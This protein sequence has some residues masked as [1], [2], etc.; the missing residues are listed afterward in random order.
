MRNA[1]HYR[2]SLIYSV[3]MLSVLAVAG[4]VTSGAKGAAGPP[5]LGDRME[6][7]R[8]CYRFTAGVSFE[9]HPYV[10]D[11]DNDGL[12]DL[13]VGV[14]E[15]NLH[16][17]ANIGSAS[18]PAL[19]PP[20][21]VQNAYGDI[22]VGMTA[23]PVHHDWNADGR[24]DLLVGD[25][26]GRVAFFANI[27]TDS[28][29]IF[30][31][32]TTLTAGGVTLDV[33][34]SSTP[35]VA[36]WNNDGKDD[37]LV[38]E[39]DGNINLFINT[40]T[41]AAPVLAAGVLL[42][43]GG[44][45]IDM[46]VESRPFV[47]DWNGDGRKDL[48]SN[49]KPQWRLSVFINTGTDAAPSF[50][51]ETVLYDE[52][53]AVVYTADH[54]YCF[55]DVN[56]DGADDLI[57]TDA[58]EAAMYYA[59]Q[60]DNDDRM[61]ETATCFPGG[62]MEFF[63]EA[64]S[65][66]V[67]DWDED[68]RKDIFMTLGHDGHHY[69]FFNTGTNA[70]PELGAQWRVTSTV[71]GKLGFSNCQYNSPVI[72][73]WDQDG[74]KDLLIVR[75]REYDTGDVLLYLNQGENYHP[76]FGAGEKLLTSDYT[77]LGPEQS[78]GL[79]VVDWNNDGKKDLCI[80][81]NMYGG[82][83][84]DGGTYQYL[85]INQGT[86][87]APVFS[88]GTP[89]MHGEPGYEAPMFATWGMSPRIWDYEEDGDF[90]ILLNSGAESQKLTNYLNDGLAGAPHFLCQGFLQADGADLHNTCF[91]IPAVVDWNEDGKKDI[92]LGAYPDLYWYENTQAAS[93][94]PAEVTALTVAGVTDSSISLA[95]T[96]PVEDD[97][98]GVLIVRSSAAIQWLPSDQQRYYPAPGVEVAPGVTVVY[99]AGGDHSFTPWTDTGLA[100]GT[101]YY[102]RA[103]S[104][105]AILPL[106]SVSGVAVSG[107]TSGDT[108]TPTPSP[109]ATATPSPTG[110]PTEPPVGPPE[111]GAPVEI[112]REAH[113]PVQDDYYY[114]PFLTD[115]DNDGRLDLLTGCYSGTVYLSMN[116]GTSTS[117]QMADA[118]PL[119][120][121]YST[122]NVGGHSCP[123]H[124]DW[125]ADGKRDLLVGNYSGHI[126]FYEN[127]GS[128]TAPLF[129][130][131]LDLAADYATID[132]GYQANPCVVDWNNDTLPDLVAGASDG[133]IHLFLNNGSQGNPQLGPEILVE[134]G[135]T[136]INT[137]WGSSPRVADWNG[138]GR[139]D[140]LTG[141]TNWPP[142]VALFLNTGT[143]Q[144]PVFDGATQLFTD[145]SAVAYPYTAGWTL[146][147]ING[148]TLED[149]VA[150]SPIGSFLF[151]P[152]T[153]DNAD[154][155]FEYALYIPG[156]EPTRLFGRGKTAR[157]I[158]WDEDGRKDLFINAEWRARHY[159]VLNTGTATEPAFTRQELLRTVDG[160]RI[161]FGD[162][163]Y[164]FPEVVDWDND[165]RKDLLVSSLDYSDTGDVYLYLNQGENYDPAFAA[166][167]KL[168]SGYADIGP[169]ASRSLE[170]ADWN[171]DGKKDLLIG[172]YI[173]GANGMY[174][175]VMLNSGTDAAPV[176]DD[177]SILTFENGYTAPLPGNY[178]C[179]VRVW[180][181]EEDGDPDIL[182][183]TMNDYER[184]T[185]YINDGV[186]GS[187]HLVNGGFIQAD[188]YDLY[189][190]DIALPE[191]TDWD[192]DGRKDLLVSQ[193]Y[194]MY[195]YPNTQS[196]QSAPPEAVDF[197]AVA[198]DD[199]AVELTW[200]NPA[201]MDFAG[202]IIVRSESSI[203]WLPS[204]RQHYHV[205]PG[206]EVASGVTVVYTGAGDHSASPWMDSGLSTGIEY[207]YRLFTFDAVLPSY[208]VQGAE[209]SVTASAPS[210]TPEPSP[211]VEPSPT[212]PPSPTPTPSPTTPPTAV[213]TDT[214]AVTPTPTIT[215]PPPPVPA[216]GPMG[217]LLAIVLLS[218][219][220]VCG[221]KRVQYACQGTEKP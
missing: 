59:N 167:V 10:T 55:G 13:L 5:E 42:A 8:E 61:Y 9:A 115:W 134:A 208:S 126:Q 16:L 108:P 99:A 154:R 125:N 48:F 121:D 168:S 62:S 26:S 174:Q 140:L 15:G 76:E 128:D 199:E 98:G 205:T 149:F 219:L 204:D 195:W 183:S 144:A 206:S 124:F 28:V 141:S 67:V 122:L 175:Y 19:A 14:N 146:G 177:L 173:Y 112:L 78:T 82:G 100:Q 171:S 180:D 20:Q 184:L 71:D 106:Y 87:Q 161:G 170:T 4:P 172:S 132:L 185:S 142:H 21:V 23:A 123:L 29:P 17:C 30:N 102:Y 160:E 211:T 6:I 11:W 60:G 129:Y 101:V 203:T 25:T 68:G 139:K 155:E 113:I 47:L 217:G 197:Q 79:E 43:A 192:E 35:F 92:L 186:P 104:Y 178:Y 81:S 213:A 85:F 31:S 196:E 118:V 75:T 83:W 41:N 72:A 176:L 69:V 63:P 220:A 3:L 143:D 201:V 157:V 120:A 37:L 145:D 24:R 109:T 216:L 110:T 194:G 70:E 7:H 158:D 66:R 52:N 86:D 53:G 32:G 54:G 153:G 163:A 152:N 33:G 1:P 94:A 95:W 130:Y 189:G 105:D 111:F 164:C 135:G 27:G 162:N 187:P 22:D 49:A 65:V 209:L 218:C 210:P 114:K 51:S 127:M 181:F 138:D 207:Y 191:V 73:D 214:P 119:D 12:M 103:F 58:F 80:G 91:P 117:P 212:L 97:F 166:P 131:S 90:D 40:G 182:M 116:I 136:I 64:K 133:R 107:M 190:Y 202:V 34:S 165:G 221:R 193:I 84:P 89:L 198:V 74:R 88:Y 96:N 18:E 39:L 151:Y 169:Q 150:L 56:G 46:G 36:D 44:S 137:G 50:D 38:G 156:E 148:D 45:V 77:D 200:T 188:G 179:G 2:R 57:M 215:P 159:L 93:T 147:D